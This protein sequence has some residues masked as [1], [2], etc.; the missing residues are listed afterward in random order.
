MPVSRLD[1][2]SDLR[3]LFRDYGRESTF[4][5]HAYEWLWDYL[6]ELEADTDSHAPLEVD[7]IALC[8]DYSE[9]DYDTVAEYYRI[10]LPAQEEGEDDNTYDEAYREAILDYLRDKTVVLGFDDD[11]VLYAAF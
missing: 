1:S 5:H 3:S 4:S 9:E 10:S 7:V 2:A 8:C 11:S 6:E